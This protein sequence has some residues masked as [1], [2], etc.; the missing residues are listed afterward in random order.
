MNN[1][2]NASWKRNIG[3]I[4]VTAAQI[5]NAVGINVQISQTDIDAIATAI[6]GVLAGVGV[7]HDYGRKILVRYRARKIGKK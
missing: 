6:G 2:L 5:M 3:I 4:I 1:I 7:L